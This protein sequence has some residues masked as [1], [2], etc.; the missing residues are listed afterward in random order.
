[1]FS[2]L[3]R[4]LVPSVLLIALVAVVASAPAHEP[5]LVP[6]ED[7][8]ENQGDRLGD[9][10][11]NSSY[12]FYVDET[13]LY[14]A[15]VLTDY[16]SLKKIMAEGLASEVSCGIGT[17]E[18]GFEFSSKSIR[19]WYRHGRTQPYPRY[20]EPCKVK[21]KVTMSKRAAGI[22]AFDRTS[23]KLAAQV[24]PARE[25]GEPRT[26]PQPRPSHFHFMFPRDVLKKLDRVINI[27]NLKLSGSVT[28][29]TRYGSRVVE[30]KPVRAE[31]AR[32]WSGKVC[33]SRGGELT[34]RP[35]KGR[36][37]CPSGLELWG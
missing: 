18:D 23:F 16:A 17:S 1:M 7:Y 5:D 29:P 9:M 15:E 24:Y 27:R 14:G 2:R 30:L 4:A 19:D 8:A 12:V 22:L 28:G 13:T 35:A 10:A 21:A 26:I 33:T 11:P 20:A 36:K 32:N 6:E 25:R 37:P 34:L 3:A 31:W